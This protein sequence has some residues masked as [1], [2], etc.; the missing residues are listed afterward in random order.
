M[1]NFAFALALMLGAGLLLSMVAIANAA[2]FRLS[3]RH[4]YYLAAK[5]H[6]GEASADYVSDDDQSELD[7]GDKRGK[8]VRK[9]DARLKET[10]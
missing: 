1:T 7:L 8:A 6:A 3:Q 4:R 5:A 2:S 9:S 10:A